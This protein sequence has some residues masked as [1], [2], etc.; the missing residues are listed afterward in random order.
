MI[1]HQFLNACAEKFETKQWIQELSAIDADGN[2]VTE[3]DPDAVGYCSLGMILHI[4]DEITIGFHR[5][6]AGKLAKFI[7]ENYKPMGIT[8]PIFKDF[9]KHSDPQE[10][11]SCWNDQYGMTKEIVVT[12]FKECAQKLEEDA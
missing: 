9:T 5:E 3:D 12:A 8:H 10:V 2:E 7:Q 11:I 1:A 4:G 6:V